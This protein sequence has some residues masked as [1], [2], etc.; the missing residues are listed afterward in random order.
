[1]AI[2]ITL[3]MTGYYEILEVESSAS[4]A[5]IKKAYRKLAL[6][7]H[8]DKASPE[9]RESS[10]ELF[11]EMT[12]A[13]EVLMDEELRNNYDLYGSENGPRGGYTGNAGGFEDMFGGNSGGNDFGPDDFADFFGGGMP[14]GRQQ[15][16]QQR[17]TRTDDINLKVGVSLLDL[18]L[19][20]IIKHT[21]ERQVNCKKCEGRGLRKKA[22]PPICGTC[23]GHGKLNRVKSFGGMMFM[24]EVQCHDCKGDGV[25][26]RY[27]D[28]CKSCSG[29]GSVASKETMEFHLKRGAPSEGEIRLHGK[30]NEKSGLQTGDVVLKYTP[31]DLEKETFKREGNDLYM[32]IKIKLV[33]ALAGFKDDHLV[34]TLD[35]RWISIK[36][37][38]GQVITPNDSIV[39]SGEGMP[40]MGSESFGD[41]FIG[42]DIE[43][44]PNNWILEK[45]DVQTLKR[46]LDIDSKPKEDPKD[47]GDITYG[48]F[49]VKP[50]SVLPKEFNSYNANTEVKMGTETQS[51]WFNWF[52]W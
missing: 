31:Y 32:K 10:A 7:H 23:A 49:E 27:Q 5:E 47:A 30:S 39:I 38:V 41:L 20:K 36:V 4:A 19:G 48:S 40:V 29:T 26:I 24:E 3:E 16:Q 9:T 25:K 15:Q 33:E 17:K 50:K 11:K 45:N 28:K 2:F 14:G 13:Y 52:K 18:Y 1:M 37:P 44:P 8:P 34:K 46:V 42:V 35:G 22:K 43:F 21:I 12:H 51:S 6:K